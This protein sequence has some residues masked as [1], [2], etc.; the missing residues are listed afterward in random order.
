MGFVSILEQ[1]RINQ[2]KREGL[3]RA[4]QLGLK[5][6]FGEEGLPLLSAVQAQVDVAVLEFADAGLL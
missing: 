4:I 1:M 2:G 3:V 6:K 5:L